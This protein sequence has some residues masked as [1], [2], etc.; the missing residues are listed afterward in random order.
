MVAEGIWYKKK[1]S[2][3]FGPA[4]GGEKNCH[5]SRIHESFTTAAVHG[6]N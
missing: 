3:E 6:D 1:F 5:V 2:S 4:K